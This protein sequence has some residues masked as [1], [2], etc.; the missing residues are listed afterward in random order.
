MRPEAS[1]HSLDAGG[2]VIICL[3]AR[4]VIKHQ[5]II[6]F[7]FLDQVFPSGLRRKY[8]EGQSCSYNVYNR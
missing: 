8:G 2:I 3:L 6:F 5:A 4:S 7:A 1:I